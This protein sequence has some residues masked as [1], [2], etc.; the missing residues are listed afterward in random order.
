[1]NIDKLA[2]ALDQYRMA[3]EN[4]VNNLKEMF[5]GE[6]LVPPGNE[7]PVVRLSRLRELT[8]KAFDY[9]S[10]SVTPLQVARC[11]ARGLGFEILEKE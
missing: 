4:A 3:R 6:A 7:A 1:M 11:V 5:A 2:E 9:D 10:V 8:E